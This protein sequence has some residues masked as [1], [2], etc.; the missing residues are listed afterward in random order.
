MMHYSNDF[1]STFPLTVTPFKLPQLFGAVTHSIRPS[2][3]PLK[4]KIHKIEH[5][6]LDVLT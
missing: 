2:P 6:V 3:I 1:D 5:C 4:K